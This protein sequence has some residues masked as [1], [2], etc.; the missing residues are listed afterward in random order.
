MSFM[1]NELRDREHKKNEELESVLSLINERLSQVNN[2]DFGI[3]GNSEQPVIF[4]MGNARSGSTLLLQWL[5][6]LGEFSYPSNIISRFYEAPYIGSLIHKIFIDLDFKGELFN[7]NNSDIFSSNLGKTKGPDAPHEFWYFW[8][9][10]FEFGE[11]QK[12]ENITSES[13]KALAFKKELMAIPYVFNK[14]LVLKGMILNWDIGLL[15][16]LFPKSLFIHLERDPIYNMHSLY[17]AR[18]NFFGDISQ[19]YSFKPP[20]YDGLKNM[21]ALKQIAGQVYYTNRAITDQFQNIDQSK[22]MSINYEDFCLDPQKVYQTIRSKFELQNCLISDTYIGEESFSITNKITDND[23]D[24]I[25]ALI[26][27]NE[28]KNSKTS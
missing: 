7:T 28:F 24:K 14:P 9:R 2:Y 23:F 13:T 19:W 1:Q 5:A 11:I 12:L 20:E 16:K 15:E 17:K 21:T 4:I 26:D 27:Y 22:Q 6:S 25:K 18:K 10:F 3:A 8:R